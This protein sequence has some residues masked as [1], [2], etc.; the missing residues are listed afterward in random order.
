MSAKTYDNVCA[1]HRWQVP[2]RYNIAADVCDRHPRDK[3]AMIWESFDG[4]T[5]EARLGRAAG[6]REPGGSRAL[7]TRGRPG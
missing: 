3:P 2:Q 7:G 6:S 5:R 4:S 1:A